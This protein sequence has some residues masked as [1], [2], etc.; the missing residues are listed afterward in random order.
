LIDSP[1][2]FND[3][4]PLPTADRSAELQRLS[5]RAFQA[6]LPTDKFVFRDE[7]SEDA[8]VDASIELI[9]KFGESYG[10]T[11]LR[12]QVQLKG[13]DS[14]AINTDGSISVRIK[15]SNLNYLLTGPSPLFVL[16]VAARD[17]LR[18]A[19]ARDERQRLDEVNPDWM[20]QET[21]TI[22]FTEQLTPTTFDGIYERI[23]GE[24]Q[25]QRKIQDTLASASLGEQVVI[26]INPETL[27]TTNS[28]EVARMLLANG[29]TL[30]SSGF[31]AQ[32]IDSFRLLS[33]E[34]S[35]APRL[36]LVHAYAHHALARYQAALVHL[37]DAR[38]KNEDLTPSDQHFLIYLRDACEFQSGR[39]DLTEYSR[40]VANWEGLGEGGF[41]LAH[42]LDALRYRLLNEL[43][44]SRREKLFEELRLTVNEVLSQKDEQKG[45]KLQARLIMLHAE[46]GQLGT[47]FIQQL[48]NLKIQEG[49]KRKPDA[50]AVMQKLAVQVA[51]WEISASKALGEAEAESHPL[52]IAFALDTRATIRILILSNLRLFNSF[53]NIQLAIPETLLSET[54]KD[55]ERAIEIYVQAGHL[56]GELRTKMLLADLHLLA[57]RPS[58]AQVLAREVLP[59]AEVM[60]YRATKERALEHLEGKAILS[61]LEDEIKRGQN[62]DEDLRFA[63]RTD[64]EL[65]EFASDLLEQ[66][67]LPSERLPVL[68]REVLSERA[69]SQERLNWCRYI[70]MIQNLRHTEH[71]ATHYQKD[72][73]KYCTCEKYG[74]ESAIGYPDWESV[75]EA[76]KR[77]YCQGC[78]GREPKVKTS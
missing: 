51:N 43:D 12:S 24:G 63:A 28:S 7:R 61:R 69:I 54:A 72:P 22:H 78:P 20:S 40:R 70:G 47:F 1:N 59:K 21:I 66:L 36:Q 25:M 35:R 71:P 27:S 46:G 38:L 42:R 41:A 30:V 64:E 49:L 65:R 9:A 57:D 33:P 34:L 11:N 23:R 45:F 32:V 14:E 62:E 73:D 15:P 77:T 50:K 16:H 53:S 75:I 8:G 39:I 6:I 55:M 5:F 58:E 37:Q 44:L 2:S 13:T 68:E 52:L 31:A 60:E 74:Y 4:G 17:E 3:S 18:F 26:S 76:F 56:E 67:S 29:L 19:W 10:Y 48:F